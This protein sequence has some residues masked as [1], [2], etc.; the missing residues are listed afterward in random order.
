[1]AGLRLRNAV[2]ASRAASEPNSRADSSAI[3]S[4]AGVDAVEQVAGEQ[5]LGLA[6]A[7]GGAGRE[8]GAQL[9]GGR[10]RGR[11]PGT[12]RVTRPIATA[13]APVKAAPLRQAYAAARDV[14][15]GST[16]SEMTAG[17]RPSLTSVSAKVASS[18]LSTMSQ[19]A[20]MPMPPARTGPRTTATT[21]LD[22]ATT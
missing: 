21:G 9:G 7:L 4:A 17:A 19:A 20:T 1:M 18:A 6:Q 22:I 5:R 11:R 13:S 10:R 14:S 8:L 12:A 16:V 15:R 2:I 3:S